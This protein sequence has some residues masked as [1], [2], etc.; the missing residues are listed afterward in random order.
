MNWDYDIIVIGAGPA[1]A[2]LAR[3]LDARYRV[4]VVDGSQGREKV[5]GGLL[6]PDAQDMLAR[7]DISLPKDIL[8]SPQL[9]SVRT[10]DLRD[11]YTKYYRR[12][13]MNV[14]RERFD[15]FIAAMI[16]PTVD[17]VKARCRRVE[18]E[19]GGFAV[20]LAGEGERTYRCRYVVG[21]DGAGSIV[22]RALYPNAKIERYTAIQQWFDASGEDAYYSCVFDS[23]TSPGCSWIFF[24]DGSLVFGGAFATQ[25]SRDA[26][27]AQKS[28]LVS[29]GIVPSEIFDHPTRTEAC[30]VCRP[31]LT[32]GVCFGSDGAYLIGEAAGLISPSSFEGI[33]Y[34][35]HSGQLLAEAFDR[36]DDTRRITAYYRRHAAKLRRKVHMKCIKRPF[37]YQPTLRRLVMKSGLMS[38]RVEKRGKE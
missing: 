16:P 25:G 30:Q 31:H 34:A 21:A 14:S 9:F 26:F 22:R 13:Y 1:G 20:T 27:E 6:S 8:V 11:G 2:N 36:V 19:Q 32:H 23:A 15:A 10:I 29:L 5:C 33:S 35:L 17:V 7:Y 38:V 4:L 18:R 24:K 12:N 37:M 3:L 28:K